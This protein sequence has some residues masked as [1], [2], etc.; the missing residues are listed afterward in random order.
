LDRSTNEICGETT[1]TKTLSAPTQTTRK[2]RHKN[3]TGK[4]KNG[5]AE[6]RYHPKYRQT[7]TFILSL[8]CSRRGNRAKTEYQAEREKMNNPD[9]PNRTIFN[10]VNNTDKN[11]SVSDD[12]ESRKICDLKAGVNFWQLNNQTIACPTFM[13]TGAQDAAT[14]A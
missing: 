7:G 5:H 11:G 13:R 14:S 9:E 3:T 12:S 2:N 4:N 1:R 10:S 8:F 6:D